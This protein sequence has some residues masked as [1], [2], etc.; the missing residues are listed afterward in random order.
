MTLHDLAT[1]CGSEHVKKP[2]RAFTSFVIITL[3]WA[4]LTVA[5]T[6]NYSSLDRLVASVVVSVGVSV[7]V[8]VVVSGGVLF[9]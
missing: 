6:S 2:R 8:I 5:N 9:G 7:G 4:A 1:L 3:C